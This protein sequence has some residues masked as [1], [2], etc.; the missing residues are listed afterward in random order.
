MLQQKKNAYIID[1]PLVHLT[2]KW[3]LCSYT[4]TILM[5]FVRIRKC[6][7]CK[8]SSA[9]RPVPASLQKSKNSCKFP[10]LFALGFIT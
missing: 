9:S 1:T 2:R 10:L 6:L 8:P 5:E 3:R 4:V 7:K